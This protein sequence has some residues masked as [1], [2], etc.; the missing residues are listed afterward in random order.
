MVGKDKIML[1][2][3]YCKRNRIKCEKCS[4][5]FDKNEEDEHDEE[6]GNLS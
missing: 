3:A 5:F 2:E 4:K 6:C 1:H